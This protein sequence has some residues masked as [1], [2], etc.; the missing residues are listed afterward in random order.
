MGGKS[1]RSGV[2]RDLKTKPAAEAKARCRWSNERN[3]V[4]PLQNAARSRTQRVCVS[5]DTR[6]LLCARAQL[7]ALVPVR[8]GLAR[9]DRRALYVGWLLGVQ[10][11]GIPL[12]PNRALLLLPPLLLP[13]R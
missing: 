9:D 7:A 10:Q 6:T 3:S 1:A 13:A 11:G 5:C 2:W 8:A 12:T 4:S